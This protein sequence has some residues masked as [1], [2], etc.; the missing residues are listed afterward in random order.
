MSDVLSH[1]EVIIHDPRQIE[2][3]ECVDPARLAKQR[4]TRGTLGIAPAGDNGRPADDFY[5]TPAEATEALIE[6]EYIGRVWEPACGDGAISKVL[7]R[8]G[9]IVL[10]TD[11]YDHGYGRPGVDFLKQQRTAT[12]QAIVTNPPFKLAQQFVEHALHLGAPKVCM[13][14]RLA[15]LEGQRRHDSGLWAYCHRVHVFTNRMTLW[16]GDHARRDEAKGGMIAFAWF[17]WESKPRPS[18]FIQLAHIPPQR[19]TDDETMDL[20]YEPVPSG[21]R[22][23]SGGHPQAADH[24]PRQAD[25]P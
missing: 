23:G 16:R 12:R 5:R 22:G 21:A 24:H 14:L 3:A 19:E 2:I 1:T 20:V 7:E 4:A 25:Q 13:F 15:F 9:R 8:S 10:S 11:L 17:V 6:R 18:E